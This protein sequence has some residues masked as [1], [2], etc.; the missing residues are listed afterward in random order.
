MKITDLASSGHVVFVVGK[1]GVGRTTVACALARCAADNGLRTLIV[2][3]EGRGDAAHCFGDETPLNWQER[4]LYSAPDN[5]S[6]RTPGTVIGRTITPDDA[7]VEWLEEHGLRGVAR[8]LASTGALDIV[9]TGVPGVRDL[10]MLGKIKQLERDSNFDLIIVDA[11]ASG[12]AVTMFNAPVGLSKAALA[13]PIRTQ[14][15]SVLE[16]LSDPT[17]AQVLLVTTPDETPIREMLETYEALDKTTPVTTRGVIVNQVWTTPDALEDSLAKFLMHN[18]HTSKP[19][20]SGP[21]HEQEAGEHHPSQVV[22]TS[23]DGDGGHPHSD[24]VFVDPRNDASPLA[25]AA[26][27]R[28]AI[29]ATQQKELAVLDEISLL[30]Q[31]RLP[32]ETNSEPA[33]FLTKLAHTIEIGLSAW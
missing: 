2:D 23:G 29:S 9:A 26:R 32:W 3:S 4:V 27:Y 14:A 33:K 16:F 28:L 13:G 6:S 21:F 20:Q 12:H 24:F 11:P 1:G 17:R 19:T 25:Q 10:L 18:G 31:L 30:R 8:R 7:L 5:K 15:D 22:G